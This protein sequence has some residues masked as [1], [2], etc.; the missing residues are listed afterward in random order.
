MKRITKEIEKTIIYECAT[1]QEEIYQD[2]QQIVS[3]LVSTAYART[4]LDPTIQTQTQAEEAAKDLYS[5]LLIH[6]SAIIHYINREL[7]PT[8]FTEIPTD[9]LTRVMDQNAWDS[10]QRSRKEIQEVTAAINELFQEFIAYGDNHNE[11]E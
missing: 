8:K 11:E 2:L 3:K 10:I 6:I 9:T 4:T 1:V 5:P 7:F